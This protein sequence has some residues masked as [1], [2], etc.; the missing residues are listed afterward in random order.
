MIPD[1]NQYCTLEP[2]MISHN[3]TLGGIAGRAT[4][5]HL[6]PRL[7]AFLPHR[8][9][10]LLQVLHFDQGVVGLQ[11]VGGGGGAGR[12]HRRVVTA[13]ETIGEKELFE[14]RVFFKY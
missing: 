3:K 4:L 7:P 12:T 9:A 13:R 10:D 8:A 5:P 6:L 14:F 1:F 2:V 11:N